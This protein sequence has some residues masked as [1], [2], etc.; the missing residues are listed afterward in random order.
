MTTTDLDWRP[1][2]WT[3]TAAAALEEL[4]TP[5]YRRLWVRFTSGATYSY[6]GV[7][8]DVFEG[9][10]RASSAGHYLWEVIRGKG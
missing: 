10:L 6:D 9:L 4:S 7:P 2:R 3:T 1:R 5:P 8:R